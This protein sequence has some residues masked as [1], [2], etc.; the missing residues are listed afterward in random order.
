MNLYNGSVVVCM[1]MHGI[2][3][4]VFRRVG[5]AILRED[6]G[7]LLEP[8]RVDLARTG[9]VTLGVGSVRANEQKYQ[10]KERWR[11][12]RHASSG[13]RWGGCC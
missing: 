9:G 12:Q 10:Q 2:V 11:E 7:R 6:G 1:S 4:N 13:P 8:L 3:V 5:P